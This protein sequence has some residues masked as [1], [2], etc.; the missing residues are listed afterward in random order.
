MISAG[1][2]AV[3]TSS[4]GFT[5]FGEVMHCFRLPEPPF[6]ICRALPAPLSYYYVCWRKGS[7]DACFRD[8]DGCRVDTPTD[9]LSLFPTIFDMYH[10]SYQLCTIIT[11]PLCFSPLKQ[12][13]P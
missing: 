2:L 1:R 5:R 6:G 11:L 4:V 9:S 8:T 3:G 13:F 12:S 7:H 10:Y